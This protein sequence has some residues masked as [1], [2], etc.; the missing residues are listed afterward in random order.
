ML[1]HFITMTIHNALLFP[2]TPNELNPGVQPCVTKPV[3]LESECSMRQ[4]HMGFLPTSSLPSSPS[5]EH[6]L[7]LPARENGKRNCLFCWYQTRAKHALIGVFGNP[8]PSSLEPFRSVAQLVFRQAYKN[9]PIVMPSTTITG[10]G[11]K[12]RLW[13]SAW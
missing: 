8:A 9:N 1:K 5:P 7:L 6:S 13:I 3:L 4:G 12:T 11:P 2:P 10:E